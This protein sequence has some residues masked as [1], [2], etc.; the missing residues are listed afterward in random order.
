MVVGFCVSSRLLLR[1]YGCLSMSDY[2]NRKAIQWAWAHTG[3]SAYFPAL[4]KFVKSFKLFTFSVPRVKW[5][6]RPLP[7]WIM[8]EPLNA[9]PSTGLQWIKI[10]TKR[11]DIRLLS[12]N[13]AKTFDRVR[14]SGLMKKLCAYGARGWTSVKDGCQLPFWSFT[15][16][17]SW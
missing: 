2:L 14:H 5:T 15:L 10:L 16:G 11:C 3:W 4:G 7:I 13:I 17:C 6:F 12:F 9:W 1:A 8:P